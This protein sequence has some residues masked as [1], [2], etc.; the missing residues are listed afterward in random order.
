[1]ND[2][3]TEEEKSKLIDAV[4]CKFPHN[5]IMELYYNIGRALPFTAQRFPDG[6]V[7][8]W[9]RSQYVQVVKV[10]PHGKYG[11]YG[12]A[13]GFYYRNGERADSSDI[14]GLCWCKKEDQE[15]QEIPNSGCGSWMLLDIQGEPST[16]NPKVLGLDDVIDFGKYKGVTIR[17]VIKKDWQYIEWAVLQ[18][19]RLYVDVEAV[20]SYHESC[21]VSLKPSDVMQFGKYKGQS[22]ACWK[23][24]MTL[25]ES[26]GILFKHKFKT[27]MTNS[28]R[29]HYTEEEL[30]WMTGGN[31]GTLPVRI[32]P[33]KINILEDNEIFV[34]GS[35]I[36]GMHMGGAARAAYNKFGAEWGNGE[37]L[38]G[39]SYALPTMEG[40]DSTKEAV[41]HFTQCAKTHQ[42]LKFYVTPVGCGIA[43]YTSKE[44]GPLF[45]DAAEL[46]N[47]YLPISFW[48]VLLGITD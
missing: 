11:K 30:Y 5:N 19:Q 40:L 43:G 7:S 10:M 46:S 32:T 48:K 22:L 31:T 27:V 21:I 42:E 23:A 2:N 9:Y 37:G 1:M 25:L 41:G 20:I 35:N 38:Q 33:S 36:K 3:M 26:I 12:K 8:D 18:S 39:K 13:F 44:I 6:R 17:E 16:D 28:M 14:E 45:R 24:I 47:V 15:P 34:F 4:N 29:N